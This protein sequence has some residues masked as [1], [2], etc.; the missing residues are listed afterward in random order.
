MYHSVTFGDKNTWDDWCLIPTVEPVI[1]PPAPK[2]NFIDIPG[3]D[4]SLDMSEILTGYPVFSNREGSLS[5]IAMNKNA[6]MQPECNPYKFRDLVA[7][8][9]D[10]LQGKRMKMYLEDDPNFYYEG[11]FSIDRYQ[12]NINFNEISIKYVLEPYKW[13]KESSTSGSWLWDPF[14]FETDYIKSALFRNLTVTTAQKVVNLSRRIIGTAPVVPTISLSTTTNGAYFRI[15]NSE[16]GIDKT[17][18][19]QNGT[20]KNPDLFFYGNDCKLYFWVTEGSGTVSIEFR[21]GRL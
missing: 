17:L 20:S 19:F 16:L 1:D 5:F 15:V 9:M 18:Y 2:T 3:G 12:A 8:I 13:S 7:T 14:N 4:G 6:S 11:R 21:Q 10:H